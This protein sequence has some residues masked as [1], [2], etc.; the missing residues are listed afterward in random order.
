MELPLPEHSVPLSEA[1]HVFWQLLFRQKEYEKPRSSALL[2]FTYSPLGA[3]SKEDFPLLA[4]SPS[5]G[6]SRLCVV[7][8]FVLHA[9][10]AAAVLYNSQIKQNVLFAFIQTTGCLRVSP[11]LCLNRQV[12]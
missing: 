12:L 8:L 9:P 6:R 11:H 1:C 10:R 7:L 2:L 5:S 3:S 4:L